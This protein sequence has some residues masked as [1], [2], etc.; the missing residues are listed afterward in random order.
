LSSKRER[1]E[2]SDKRGKAKPF[3]IEREVVMKKRS[4]GAPQRGEHAPGSKQ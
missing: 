4:E 3:M 1:K 2:E